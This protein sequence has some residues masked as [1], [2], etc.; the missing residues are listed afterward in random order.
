[1]T[2]INKLVILLYSII[3]FAASG[4]SGGNTHFSNSDMVKLISTF[5][6]P[7]GS[8]HL[9]ISGNY[10]YVKDADRVIHVIDISNPSSP[11]EVGSID[12]R[13]S[14]AYGFE[15]SGGYAFVTDGTGLRIIDIS[16]PASPRQKGY[17]R[18][19][20]DTSSV[21]TVAISGNYAY[22]DDEFNEVMATI[23]ISDRANPV[24]VASFSTTALSFTWDIKIS[25]NYAYLTGI[26]PNIVIV[27][28]SDPTSPVQ[29][30]RFNY[31]YRGGAKCH[32]DKDYIYVA[33]FYHPAHITANNFKIF[34]ISNKKDVKLLGQYTASEDEISIHSVFSGWGYA[35]CAHGTHGVRIVDV[36]N[37]SNPVEAGIFNTSGNSVGAWVKGPYIFVSDANPG[38]KIYKYLGTGTGDSGQP[39]GSF[40]TPVEGT[41]V[42]GCVPFTGW[43]LDDVEVESVRLFREEESSLVPFGD[44]LFIEGARPDIEQAYPGYPNN[45]KAGWG[46]MMLSDFL[47]NQGSGVLIIHAIATDTKG[48]QVT[49]GTKTIKVD[50]DNANAV[51]PFGAIDTPARGGI[52]S[53]SDFVNFGWALTPMPDTIPFDGSTITIWVDGVPLG[54]PVYNQCRED[55]AALF[56]GYNNSKGA[57]GYF[58][59]DTTQYENGL[60]TIVWSVEDNGENS[61]GIGIGSKYFIIQNSEFRGH[62]PLVNGTRHV[63]YKGSVVSNDFS[64]IP[65]D[66]SSPVEVIKGFN[67][68]GVPL[69]SYPDDDDKGIITIKTRELERIEIYLNDYQAE[70]NVMVNEDSSNN[71]KFKIQNSKFYYGFQVVGN[72]L[73]PLPIGAALDKEIGVFYWHP[74]VGF[75]G[76]YRLVFIERGQNNR[77]I[78]KNIKIFIKPKF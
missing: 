60:H 10:A 42:S 57:V 31:G 40:D 28:I 13:P 20:G 76:E 4:C 19:K 14:K 75:I 62:E 17:Y 41:T 74:G 24:R 65:V 16:N 21:T 78:K 11:H 32:I 30:N 6:I 54:N 37:P 55:I 70:G 29:V 3:S 39:F 18:S 67:R 72:R 22:I 44:A 64:R 47:P 33:N 53:G 61:K 59:L 36:S 1:M 52:A 34:D 46:Y 7:G 8:G 66:D 25:G 15:V 26:D 50:N 2:G 73:R 12:I 56:P 49:L 9:L 5:E 68:N 38:L 23:D 27:D 69:K 45:Y 43:A 48:H 63:A 71:S 35:F 58:Y 51:K 77:L